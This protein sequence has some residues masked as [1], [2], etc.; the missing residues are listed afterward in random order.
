MK[1]KYIK[2]FN[3]LEKLG[4]PVYQHADDQGN[5]S[6]STERDSSEIWADYYDGYRIPGWD[7]GINPKITKVL[8]TC[9]LYAEWQNPGRLTVWEG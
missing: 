7:F 2:A 5:F 8:N 1:R 4:C 9:G 6:I 3:T